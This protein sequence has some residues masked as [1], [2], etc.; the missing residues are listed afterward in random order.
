MR[1]AHVLVGLLLTGVWGLVLPGAAHAQNVQ[2]G[3]QTNGVHLGINLGPA[4]PPLV[5]VPAPVVVAPGPPGPPP[6][7]VYYAPNQ[8]YNYFVYQNVHYLYHE[9]RWFR[10]RSHTG[11]WTAVAI[12][13]VPRP[14]LV[15]PVE[16]Y[17]N[18]SAHWKQH[19]PPPWARERER[20]RR[21]DEE[22]GRGH[23]QNGEHHDRGHGK[24]RD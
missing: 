4:P 11:P 3:V 13:Q 1:R 2:I 17:R 24:D 6:P 20:E 14:I 12:T 9:G 7:A 21:W 22:H 10:A 23:G 19:G 8:P 18:R 15:V 5:V 16:H